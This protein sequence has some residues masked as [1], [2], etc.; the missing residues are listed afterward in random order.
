MRSHNTSP[1]LNR[2]KGQ[3]RAADSA[4]SVQVSEQRTYKSL[5]REPYRERQ[6]QPS[7]HIEVEQQ[8]PIVVKIFPES[9]SWIDKQL[10]LRNTAFHAGGHSLSKEI[11]YLSHHVL[12]VRVIAHCF[13]LTLHMH[14]TDW[15]TQSPS[16]FDRALSS[17][18]T[19]IVDQACARR[20]GG[21][22]HFGF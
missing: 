22:H 1:F 21:S 12:V 19:D 20:H 6:A 18:R 10:L 3:T 15:N 5:S 8:S 17:K 16:G 14:Q 9:K 2:H 11:P 7:Q 13:R 4:V